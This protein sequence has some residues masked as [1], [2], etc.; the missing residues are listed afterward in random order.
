M[1]R[2]MRHRHPHVRFIGLHNRSVP[3][4]I[5]RARTAGL[6]AV[7][8]ED[9]GFAAVLAALGVPPL[10]PVTAEHQRSA[11]RRGALTDRETQVLRLV[12]EGL[13]SREVADRL[14]LSVK[15]V[16]NYKHRIFEKLDVQSQSQ[17]VAV[18]LRSGLIPPSGAVAG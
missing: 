18:A 1:L 12:S 15:S 16:E 7:V 4:V 2:A 3:E 13:T 17:A 14:G 10:D 9:E 8:S 11:V 6:D 5:E